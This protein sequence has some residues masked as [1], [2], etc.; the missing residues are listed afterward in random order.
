MFERLLGVSRI[1]RSGLHYAIVVSTRGPSLRSTIVAG[2]FSA[3]GP[4]NT[5][6]APL[7]STLLLP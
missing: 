6:F 4:K 2:Y 7:A 5:P 1:L 3:T